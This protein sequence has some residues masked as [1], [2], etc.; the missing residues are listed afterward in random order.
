MGLFLFLWMVKYHS[1]DF[2]SITVLDRKKKGKSKEAI[3][4]TKQAFHYGIP[5]VGYGHKIREGPW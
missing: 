5:R 4:S 2:E 1:K 3:I